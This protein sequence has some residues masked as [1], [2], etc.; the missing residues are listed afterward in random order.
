MRFTDH[1]ELAKRQRYR[2]KQRKREIIYNSLTALALIAS[3]AV[4]SIFL[5]IFSNPYLPLNP[6]P[7]PT[8]PWMVTPETLT[9][10][11]PRLPATWTP[12]P[13]I[14]ETPLPVIPTNTEVV[15]PTL[16]STATEILAV[17]EYPFAIEGDP[18]AMTNT[19]FHPGESCAWQGVAGRVV[20]MQG[21]HV[22]GVTVKLTGSYN[23]QVI[24]MNTI[25]GGASAWY[26]E[27]GYEFVLGSTLFDT[28]GTLMIQLVDQ[29]QMPIS[30]RVVFNTYKDCGKNL[31]LINFKQVR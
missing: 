6:F 27:S 26:G 19:T 11:P 12:T 3:V 23:D 29:S 30:D 18:V 9:P 1:E 5:V 8:M 22:V 10:T 16:T 15:I 7:P 21:R 31:I 4:I 24:D 20:D 17:G 28:N 13:T 2:A 25:T 14:T